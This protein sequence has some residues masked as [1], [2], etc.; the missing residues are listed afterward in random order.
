MCEYKCLIATKK[1][2]VEGK[3]GGW[4]YANRSLLKPHGLRG[5]NGRHQYLLL[6]WMKEHN[7]GKIGTDD[8]F[9][10]TNGKV[11]MEVPA[12]RCSVLRII[13]DHVEGRTGA[14][15]ET[16][17]IDTICCMLSD[18]KW[19][20]GEGNETDKGIAGKPV[21]LSMQYKSNKQEDTITFRIYREGSD[22]EVGAVEI[23][24]VDGNGER[25]EIRAEWTYDYKEVMDKEGEAYQE[26]PK[27]YFTAK[28]KDGYTLQGDKPLEM[29]MEINLVVVDDDKVIIRSAPVEIKFTTEQKDARGNPIDNPLQGKSDANGAFKKTDLIPDEIE[30][31][32]N[33]PIERSYPLDSSSGKLITYPKDLSWPDTNDHLVQLR[34]IDGGEIIRRGSSGQSPIPSDKLE[35][36]KTNIIKLP[37]RYLNNSNKYIGVPNQNQ[38]SECEFVEYMLGNSYLTR[39]IKIN[40]I[41][42]FKGM[43][44]AKQI[45]ELLRPENFPIDIVDTA[46]PN[47]ANNGIQ[48]QK[49]DQTIN[50]QT[51]TQRIINISTG[52]SLPN[53]IIYIP[54]TNLSS[55]YDKQLF[56]HE[57]FHQYQY[58]QDKRGTFKQLIQ[59]MWDNQR[60]GNPQLFPND[61]LASYRHKNSKTE[62]YFSYN[63]WNY[64]GP[65]IED[66][67][68]HQITDLQQIETYEGQAR[69]M[70][71]FTRDHLESRLLS[72]YQLALFQNRNASRIYTNVIYH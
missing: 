68:K 15:H 42:I 66:A 46:N 5:D 71:Y 45:Q 59:E 57:V 34:Q 62:N 64:A 10:L 4:D 31:A 47:P 41:Q 12:D 8:W 65:Y 18:P 39:P 26:K 50:N 61:P 9:I 38:M 40:E 55:T 53:G 70:E 1:V 52:M 67:T 51:D 44:A 43:P 58:S 24:D 13:G 48:K 23:K 29:G 21:T 2:T 33:M 37:V 20:D 6:E 56:I 30:I 25:Q 36:G 27:Y 54:N 19:L 60:G 72:D 35:M 17:Y 32:V 49:F 63:Y 22:K 11:D 16:Q 7:P 69:F 28:N 14:C 3:T